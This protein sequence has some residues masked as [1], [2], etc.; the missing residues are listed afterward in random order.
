[1]GRLSIHKLKEWKAQGRRFAMITAYDYPTARLVEQAGIPIILVGDSLGSVVLGYDS[2]VPVTMDDIVYHTRAVVRATEKAIVVAD[3][4]FMSY[5]ADPNEA[6]R[7]AG[8]LLKEGGATAVKLEGGSHIVPL[9]RRMVE[10]GIPVMG[11]LGLTPQS[12]NQFGGHKVQGKTPAAAAK[13]IAD[14]RALEDAGAFAVVLETIPAPLA[15]MVTERLSIPTIGIGAGPHCDAQVQV[16]HDMLGIYDDRRPLKHAKRYAV[17]GAAIREAVRAY[18]D[19][20]EGGAFPTAEHSF[21]M[22]EATL[23]ELAQAG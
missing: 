13:L 23:A 16:L 2:T 20:V 22:D 9:V 12:V 11:H 14:A 5:Q 8:R 19:E 18:I 15:R 3:M 6:M 1:M 7:N 10:A 21:E 17:L 4:P